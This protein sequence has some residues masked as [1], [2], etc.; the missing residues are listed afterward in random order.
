MSVGTTLEV[1]RRFF[2]EGFHVGLHAKVV[3][4]STVFGRQ[5]GVSPYG[6]VA[7]WIYRAI[8]RRF[9]LFGLL[10]PGEDR[11]CPNQT[12]SDGEH[13][14]GDNAFPQLIFPPKLYVN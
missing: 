3:S 1:F 14:C 4:L 13:Q 9:C 6:D 7:D 11:R 5:F 10:L 2:L 12:A 8:G